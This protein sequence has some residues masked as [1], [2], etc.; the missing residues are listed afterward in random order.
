MAR[1]KI[2]EIRN[3][4]TKCYLRLNET[5]LNQVIKPIMSFISVLELKYLY[6]IFSNERET[7]Q[8]LKSFYD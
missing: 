3:L 4:F 1:I 2:S 6:K 5:D 8:R 7:R